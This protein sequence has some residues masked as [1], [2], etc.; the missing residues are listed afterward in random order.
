M[1]KV[2]LTCGLVCAGKTT[3]ARHLC[4]DMPAA[5]LSA[6]EIML[7]LFGPDAGDKHDVYFARVRKYLYEKAASLARDGINTVADLGMWSREERD[8]ARHF[9]R[10]RGI[11]MEIHYLKIGADEWMRRI[12][13]RSRDISQGFSGAYEVDDGLRKKCLAAFEEP[14]GEEDV[15]TVRAEDLPFQNEEQN[16]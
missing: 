1:A 7:A 16:E 9:F 6:D 5:L 3:Y 13:R 10:D 15:T 11:E 14:E 4:A 12:R 8:R 2:I